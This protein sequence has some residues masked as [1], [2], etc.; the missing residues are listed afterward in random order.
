[1][2]EQGRDGCERCGVFDLISA[3]EQVRSV[4]AAHTG[5]GHDHDGPAT[6]EEQVMEARYQPLTRHPEAG[7]EHAEEERCHYHHHVYTEKCAPRPVRG[8]SN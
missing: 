4:L 8:P 2:A 1:M 7:V 5:E 3:F 6:L